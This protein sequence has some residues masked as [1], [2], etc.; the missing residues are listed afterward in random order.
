MNSNNIHID[1]VEVEKTLFKRANFDFITIRPDE[2]GELKKHVKQEQALKILINNDKEEFL[3]GGGAGGAKSWTGCVWLIFMCILYPSSKWF[4]GREELKRITESTLVTFFKVANQY[5][6]KDWNYNAQRHFIQ[7]ANGSRID[8]LELKYKPS[9][10]LY[11]RFGSTEYTG[12]WIEE[13]GEINFGAYDVLRTRVGRHYN[14]KY[15]VRA[16]IF[17]TCNPK[18]NWLYNEFL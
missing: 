17:I 14:D 1:V 7:F 12:G 11:E 18:K 8:L 6:V 10:P 9:D 5:K 3:Y 4:I 2:K 15:K 16:K 13:G